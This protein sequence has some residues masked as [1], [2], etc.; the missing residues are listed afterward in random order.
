MRTVEGDLISLAS[1]GLFD[2][3]AHGC[4]CF[5]KQKSGIAAQMAKAFRTDSFPFEQL[6]YKGYI[7]KLGN[8]DSKKIG[9]LWVVNCY[10]QYDYGRD[11]MYLNYEALS[12]CLLK[13]NHKFK[14]LRIGL[15]QIGCGLAGGDW[16]E[17]KY[18]IETHLSDCNVTVVVYD[19]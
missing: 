17:V 1:E 2:V 4:N 16:E 3:V 14:G 12:L 15:P 6:K 10:T 18:I 19:K 7:G 9:K 13:I 11:R 5:C 8:I